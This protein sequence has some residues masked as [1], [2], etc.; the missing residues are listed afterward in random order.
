MTPESDTSQYAPRPSALLLV[1]RPRRRLRRRNY[2]FGFGRVECAHSAH[3]ACRAITLVEGSC[4]FEARDRF[5]TLQTAN[6]GRRRITGG[7]QFPHPA[8]AQQA[9]VIDRIGAGNHP[10]NHRSDLQPRVGTLVCR[11]RQ[12]LSSQLPQPPPSQPASS[13]GPAPRP[14]QDLH[15]RRKQTRPGEYEKVASTRCP[16]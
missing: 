8:V 11:D 1:R 4:K 15:H 14:A 3:L 16:S 12:P 6:E 9:H 13:S 7:E 5:K 2:R 10:A